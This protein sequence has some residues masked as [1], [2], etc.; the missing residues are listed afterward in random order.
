VFVPPPVATKKAGLFKIRTE[1]T[2]ERPRSWGLFRGEKLAKGEGKSQVGERAQRK[3][4]L[5]WPH[6]PCSGI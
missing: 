4:E 3:T 2:S 5:L 1:K 6:Q